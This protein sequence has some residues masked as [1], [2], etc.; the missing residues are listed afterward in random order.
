MTERPILEL[1]SLSFGYGEELVITGL[2]CKIAEG[3]FVGIIGPNGAGKTTLLRMITG[4]L[5]PRG[6]KVLLWG[7]DISVLP[8]RSLA[9]D[10]ALMPQFF[11]MPLSFKVRDFVL[12][13]RFPFLKRFEAPSS[14]DFEIVGNCLE[15][16]ETSGIRERSL[17][18]LSGGE[19]QRVVL[20]QVLAQEPNLVLLDEPT[21]HLDIGHQSSVLN[22]IKN[23]NR[24]K[25]LT[26]I[27]VMHDLNLAGEYC[28]RLIL[29]NKGLIEKEGK[30]AD[31]LTYKDI[32]K[33]YNTEIFVDKNPVTKK[34]HVFLVT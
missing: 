26:V 23:L 17:S 5:K 34:P 1:I 13:G 18:E 20:A 25:G 27:S 32:K 22:V 7:E 33:V 11:D 29:M 4:F 10:I 8:K 12:M 9:K 19:K 6:G 3:A 2:S 28:D 24:D 31:V 16:T 30:S 15:M 14:H 21:S